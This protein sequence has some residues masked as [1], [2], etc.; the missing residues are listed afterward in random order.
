MDNSPAAL[1]HEVAPGYPSR[2]VD[3]HGNGWMCTP[4]DTEQERQLGEPFLYRR[5][6]GGDVCTLTQLG[7]QTGG[8]RPVV[9]MPAADRAQL[10]EV[11]TKAGKKAAATLAVALYETA[12]AAKS[13]GDGHAY[14]LLVAG[15][16]GSWESADVHRLAWETGSD[17]KLSR[18]DMW[19]GQTCEEIITRW[20]T[21]P[22]V[23]VEVAENLASVFG[24][25]VDACG[26][27]DQTS[28]QWLRPRESY[29]NYLTSLSE[30]YGPTTY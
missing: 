7:E 5:G 27:W 22:G 29:R 15:R 1:P 16:P 13:W 18:V 21:G 10:V 17:I 9:G 3:G 11:L 28:D 30:H 26:G 2:L 25:V 20:I 12:K 6:F 14:E 4:P 23:Y 8:W 19:A 24:D